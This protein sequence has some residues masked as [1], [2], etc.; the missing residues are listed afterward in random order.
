[1]LDKR[2]AFRC[3]RQ[4]VTWVSWLVVPYGD[5]GSCKKAEKKMLKPSL[6][7]HSYDV[8]SSGKLTVELHDPCKK[9]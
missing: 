7:V 1:M 5:V 4:A 9:P 8:E 6:T 2:T 3:L